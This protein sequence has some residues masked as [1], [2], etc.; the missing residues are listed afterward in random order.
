[1]VYLNLD[2]P[3]SYFTAFPR[4]L[5]LPLSCAC[6]CGC[7]NA[8]AIIKGY[9]KMKALAGAAIRI[10]D[11]HTHKHAYAHTLLQLCFHITPWQ[12]PLTAAYLHRYHQG[13]QR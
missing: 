9:V 10:S 2:A 1:M 5:P 7:S 4:S 3:V 8:S 6:V 13:Y 11:K 12:R